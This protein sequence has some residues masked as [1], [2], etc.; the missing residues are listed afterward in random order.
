[1]IVPEPLKGSSAVVWLVTGVPKTGIDLA[2]AVEMKIKRNSE[3][4]PAERAYGSAK[5]YTEL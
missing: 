5:K 2:E 4:Y 1:M 3:K